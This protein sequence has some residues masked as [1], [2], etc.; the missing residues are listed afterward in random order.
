M[1]FVCTV[2]VP[3]GGAHEE[4]LEWSGP[5]ESG[6]IYEHV[7]D[8]EQI[9]DAVREDEEGQRGGLGHVKWFQAR[10]SVL[11]TGMYSRAT[12]SQNLLRFCFVRRL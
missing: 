10:V 11:E 3:V 12:W 2:S 7:T 9:A 6:H 8:M 1:N 4:T 5:K